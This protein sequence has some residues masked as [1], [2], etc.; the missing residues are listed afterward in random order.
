VQLNA[1]RSPD[2]SFFIIIWVWGVLLGPEPI[3]KK[4]NAGKR[5]L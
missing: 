5:Q 3:G 4:E 1:K 2:I